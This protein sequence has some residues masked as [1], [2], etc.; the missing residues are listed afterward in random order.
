MLL[1]LAEDPNPAQT[2]FFPLPVLAQWQV[3]G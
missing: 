2:W 1:E 3:R